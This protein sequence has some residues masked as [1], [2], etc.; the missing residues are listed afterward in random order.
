MIPNYEQVP[1]KT[2]FV[3]KKE[4]FHDVNVP[5]HIHP[6]Y[7]LTFIHIGKGIEHVGSYVGNI[8]QMGLVFLG[9][10]LPH[11]WYIN[12]N[13]NTLDGDGNY[14]VV[15]QFSK[16]VFGDSFFD[17]QPFKDICALLKKAELGMSFH[18]SDIA[19]FGSIMESMLQMNDFDKS[20][21]LLRILYKLAS[22]NDYKVL[23]SFGFNEVLNE[24]NI[25]RMNKIL[26]YITLNFKENITLNEIANVANMTP[27]AFCK[28]FKERTHKTFVEFVNEVRIGYACRL[29]FEDNYNILQICYECGFSNL[30]NFNRQFKKIINV[31]PIG[32]KKKVNAEILAK[33]KK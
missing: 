24:N 29:L 23:S 12:K 27:Q 1:F 18:F 2:P 21:T 32:Y 7:E 11:N 14:Q 26:Q 8:D 13:F 19:E 9:P 3:L 17:I 31:S 28:Y 5:W 33:R 6:E 16:D 4:F 25:K 10:N 15:I 22:T 20:I 30:S